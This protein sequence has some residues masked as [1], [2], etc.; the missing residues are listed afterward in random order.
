MD[1]L[2][3]DLRYGVKQLWKNK[4]LTV[5][6]IISLAIGIG[7]NSVIFGLVDSILLRPRP[8]AN[9]H[10]ARAGGGAQVRIRATNI[11]RKIRSC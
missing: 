6:A 5:V 10:Q 9:P 3:Q 11:S 1:I 4:G 8:V 7:A 2:I